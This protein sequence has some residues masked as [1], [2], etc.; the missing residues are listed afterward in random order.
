M[1][2]SSISSAYTD[3]RLYVTN[4]D[5]NANGNLY[6]R[7]NGDTGSN[8][9]YSVITSDNTS[10]V[11]SA[12]DNKIVTSGAQ[13]GGTQ[14]NGALYIE[15]PNYA[16]T[17]GYKSCSTNFAHKG[18][19]GQTYFGYSAAGLPTASAISSITV[20]TDAASWTGNYQLLGVK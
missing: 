11:Q 6:L 12:A 5:L 3:L 19:G 2:L 17:N 4:I 1:T 14:V 10:V 9:A 7:L 13:Q 18:T 16:N 15:I 20:F 8:Y